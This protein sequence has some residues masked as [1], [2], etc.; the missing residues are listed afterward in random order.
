MIGLDTN[1]LVRY[2]TQD[3]P[4][5]SAR[6]NQLIESRC[7]KDEPGLVSLVVLCEL[8]WVLRGAYGYDK[9]LVVEVLDAILAAS[10]LKV[11]NEQVVRS[12]LAHFR[13]GSADFADYVITL[14]HRDAG[15]EATYSFDQKLAK[16][17]F[18]R[19]P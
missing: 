6:A 19:M 7:T 16:N 11:E 2:L 3:D 18:V 1:I 9:R 4:D 10:E 12:A 15:C 13:R 5:Q 8:A 14:G 17:K